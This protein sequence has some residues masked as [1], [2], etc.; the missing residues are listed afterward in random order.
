MRPQAAYNVAQAQAREDK[1]EI[2]LYERRIRMSILRTD[3]ERAL[4][5][6]TS[7]EEGMRFQGLAVVLGKQRWPELIARPRKKDLGLDAYA[8]ASETPENRSK[9]LAASI[10][11][12]LRKVSDDAKRA[13]ENFADLSALLFVTPAKVSNSKQKQWEEVIR[14][15]HDLE[16]HIIER[17]EIITLMMMP[18]NV[19]LCASFLHLDINTGPGALDLIDRTRRAAEVVTRNWAEKTKG[20]PL[21]DLTAVRSDQNGRESTDLL[22]LE[23]IDQALSQSRRIVLEGPA[24]RGKTTTLI[25]L[26]QRPR[27]YGIPF[28]VG[29][30]AWTT[31]RRN[32]LEFIA[33]MTALQA[34]CLTSA[35]LAR[36]QQ[37]EPF[38]LLLDG[39][40]E[41]AESSSAQADDALRELER[42]FPSAGIIVATRTHHLT[43]PLPGALPLR[44]LRLRHVQRTAYLEARLGSKSAELLACIDADP[45]LN[46]LTRT[47]FILSEV[48]SL[49]EAGAEIPPTKFGILAQV[50]H[51]QE[52][53]DEHRNSLQAAPIFGQQE[54]Y[55]KALAAKMTHRGV[56]AFSEADARTE[57][58]AVA[59][60]LVERGQIER[61]RPPE[62]LANLTAHHLLERVEYP[63]TAFR[64]EHQQFQE[65]YAALDVYAR[66]LELRDDDDDATL[67]FTADY[68]NY[69]SWAEPLRMIAE[70]LAE[71]TGDEGTDERNIRVGRKLVDM[72]LAVDLVFAGELAQLCGAAVWNEVC[73]VVGERFRGVY[74][75]ADRNFRQYAVAAMLATGAD[76][77]RDI[78]LPLFSGQDQQSRVC[79]FRLLPEIQLSSL[80]S[81]WREQVRSWSEEARADFVSVLLDHRV[82]DEIAFFAVEDNSV[83]VK[84]AAVSGLMWTGSDDALTRVLKS[85]DAQTFDEV[86]RKN[87]DRMPP[88]LR[89]KTIA[90]MWKFIG[91]MTD[92]PARLQTALE[93][94]ELG[95]PGADGVVKSAMAA[96]PSGDMRNLVPHYIL[97]AIK[98]LHKTDP[99][100]VSEW[101]AKRI[102]E[103]VLYGQEEWLP[104]A[105][106]IPDNLID[107]YVHCLE[108]EDLNNSRFEGMVALVA[109]RVDAKLAA[110]VFSKLRELRRRVDA[111]PGQRHEIE[112]QVIRQLKALFRRL[113][114][115]TIVSGILSSVMSGDPLDITVTADL[116]STVAGSDLEQLRVADDDQKTQL[117]AYLK[118]SVDLMLTQDD[119]NGE[120]KANLASSIAQVGKPDDISDLIKLIRAD[121]ERMRRGSAARAAGDRGPLS[122]GASYSYARWHIAAVMHLDEAGSEQVLIDLLPEPEY[123]SDAAA[124]MVRDFLPKRESSFARKF[125]YDLMWTARED[126]IPTLDND[127]R[128]KGFGIALNAEIERL[129]EQNQ[130]GK[131]AAGIKK[132]ASALAAVDGR[133]S[134]VAVINAIANPGQSD[135]YIC[136]E[137]AERLLMAGIVLPKSTVLTLVDSVLELTKNW[138]S[139]SDRYLLC[140]IL[141]LCPF[142]NDPPAGIAKMRDVIDNRRLQGHDLR[143]LVA[144]LGESRADSAVDLLFE[145]ASDVQTFKQCEDDF[146]NAF[147]TLDTPRARELLLGF[148]DPDIRAIGLTRRPH[149][150]DVLVE[151][152]TQLARRSPKAAAQLRDLCE[153]D[154][155]E[156]N[157]YL[158]SIVMSRIGT[159]ETLVANLNLIDDARPSSVPQGVRDQLENALIKRQSH[160]QSP[161]VFTL[162]ARA[163]NKLRTRLIGM[164][165]EDSKR[166]ISAFKLLGQI[167]VW[168]LEH[169]RPTDEPRHPDLASGQSWPPKQP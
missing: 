158:L 166:Q 146:I 97:P 81:N 39:W 104:Y 65:Y 19:S 5:E 154:L 96:L 90:A 151:R 85:M 72:A 102:T 33:G 135:Q 129:Q 124:T 35:D 70:T 1:I 61:A 101:V 114:D 24:G 113:P 73:A 57:I 116:L 106:D 130:D 153:R 145:L 144:A 58:A 7:Q 30:S 56:V 110:H 115:D 131:P 89:S 59:G 84:K 168:R 107:T 48:T 13:K 120:K 100:W 45:S 15:N 165:L 141:A 34:E 63:E 122:N 43:P 64:F 160:G 51:L 20:H 99:T 71:Q 87:A 17:E 18:K 127:K 78:I 75:S 93:L 26:A 80:G 9:G 31:S 117:R 27:A 143:E 133:G 37:T 60:E 86:A 53:R 136:L 169:G 47:P 121:I 108:T 149:D 69:P 128:R 66:L 83:A 123:S 21:I 161:H 109:A 54:D 152:L 105:T 4:D 2:E 8:P 28:I 49:F 111:K 163:S 150:G 3:I 92:H 88:A 67:R 162:H 155:S 134:V 138:M 148:V 41:I 23:Q 76:D 94:I 112:W 50:L 142:V 42:D 132:L 156:T 6:L 22:L 11:P 140:R 74:A 12:T 118:D 36:V 126:R 164:A 62:V 139:D 159:L 79:T 157:R 16:L 46:E 98:Y 32:I 77:F 95:E 25:Q 52:Q 147:A 29:L 82:D 10:T 119:F 38:L 55:L 103:G 40:N 44:L 14:Q 137:A 167:E 125:P 68:V 91:S